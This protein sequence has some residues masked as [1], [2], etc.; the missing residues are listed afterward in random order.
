MSWRSFG[1]KRGTRLHNDPGPQPLWSSALG[2]RRTH[3]LHRRWLGSP[4]RCC[5]YSPNFC[6]SLHSNTIPRPSRQMLSYSAPRSGAC[7]LLVQASAQADGAWQVRLGAPQMQ[8]LI[9]C[10]LFLRFPIQTSPMVLLVLTLSDGNV[11]KDRWPMTD[12]GLFQK[13]MP[14]R[15]PF[16]FCGLDVLPF[17]CFAF[18]ALTY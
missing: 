12:I 9:V 10:P 4:W 2:P 5:P 17:S 6:C 3:V 7:H 15:V 8:L 16:S 1:K 18:I 14:E 13:R 11:S